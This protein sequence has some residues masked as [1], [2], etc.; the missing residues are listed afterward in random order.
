M[1]TA[2][3]AVA[4]AH[5]A[6]KAMFDYPE[7]ESAQKLFAMARQEPAGAG[8]AL[9]AVSIFMLGVLLL[10]GGQVRAQDVQLHPDTGACVDPRAGARTTGALARSPSA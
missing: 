6:R 3:V 8:L 10:F 5:W 4:L 1:A 7:A 2:L 9:V